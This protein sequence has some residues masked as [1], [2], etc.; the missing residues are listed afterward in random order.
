M[1]PLLISLLVVAAGVVAL[2]ARDAVD[3]RPV[4]R[5]S[6]PER[7]KQYLAAFRGLPPA[8]QERVRQLDKD[9][10]DEDP[11]TRAR[12]IG[13]MERY[14]L[15]LSRLSDA[16][17]GRIQ[18][19]PAGPERLRVVRDV[20]EQQWLESLPPA[21]KAQLTQAT[22]E[23][24]KALVTRWHNEDRQR[25]QD[26]AVSLRTTQEM[27]ILGRDERMKT[28]REEVAKFVKNDLEPKLTPRE[29]KGFQ[30]VRD[31]VPS[32]YN[33]FHQ[34]LVLSEIHGLKPPGPPDIWDR[35][36]MPRR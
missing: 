27:A 4:R 24:R 7:L 31:R 28:F 15:W 16:D 25:E 1:R 20:L 22:D 19:A 32:G 8:A 9:I 2:S 23:E 10:Q 14:A 13:V 34:V 3:S 29:K 35:F 18:S 11:G 30:P 6:D 5:T 33:F 21:R 17:R 26:W 36:R 12:L